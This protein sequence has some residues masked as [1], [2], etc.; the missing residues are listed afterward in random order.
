VPL[1]KG[2]ISL[3]SEDFRKTDSGGFEALLPPRIPKSNSHPNCEALRLSRFKG[4]GADAD[5][6]ANVLIHEMGW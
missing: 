2:I 4:G 3:I 5:Q 6:L 1:A